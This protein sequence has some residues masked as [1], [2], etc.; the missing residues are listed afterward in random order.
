MTKPRPGIVV[1][2]TIKFADNLLRNFSLT[3]SVIL[4]A[5]GSYA[6]FG[7]QLTSSYLLGVVLVLVAMALFG[8]GPDARLLDACRKARGA[9]RYGARRCDGYEETTLM[10]T[11][12]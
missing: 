2:V 10:P 4:G 3:V 6:L 7:L 9:L 12:P 11:T 5:W 1:A 8:S